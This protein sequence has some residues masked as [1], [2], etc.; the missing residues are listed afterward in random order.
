MHG[1]GAPHAESL[2]EVTLPA[3]ISLVLETGPG[4]VAVKVVDG[5]TNTLC[6]APSQGTEVRLGVHPVL[7]RVIVA[8]GA[9]FCMVH[10]T[11]K[12]TPTLSAC[13]PELAMW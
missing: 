6:A 12:T 2:A 5:C 9:E 8:V 13:D 1:P 3:S 10:F 11:G 4:S 7:V